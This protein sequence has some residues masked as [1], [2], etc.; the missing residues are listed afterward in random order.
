MKLYSEL[1]V[2]TQ[3]DGKDYISVEQIYYVDEGGNEQECEAATDAC[4]DITTCADQ[5]TDLWAWLREQVEARLR[6][7]GISYEA[8][9]FDNE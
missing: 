4:I 9:Y 1:N 5:G 6:S 8:L 3:Y 7:A 2:R